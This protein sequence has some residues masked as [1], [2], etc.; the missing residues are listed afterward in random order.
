MRKIIV[1]TIGCIV[2]L[3]IFAQSEWGKAS[4]SQLEARICPID[5]SAKGMVI[6]DKQSINFKIDNRELHTYYKNYKR[7]QILKKVGFDLGNVIISANAKDAIFNVEAQI[8]NLN[9]KGE[10]AVSKLDAKQIFD[11]K[12]S[13]NVIAKKIIFPNVKEGSIIEYSYTIRADRF[14]FLNDWYF[15]SD[16]PTLSSTVVLRTP[17]FFQYTALIKSKFPLSDQKA[18]VFTEKWPSYFVGMASSGQSEVDVQGTAKTFTIKNLPA[19]EKEEYVDCLEDHLA[20]IEFVL[21]KRI[22]PDGEVTDLAKSW[23]DILEELN[24]EAEFGLLLGGGGAHI[25][26]AKLIAENSKSDLDKVKNIYEHVISKVKWDKRIRMIPRGNLSKIYS[27]GFGSSSDIN[28]ILVDMFKEVGLESD[29][30]LIRSR[31]RGRVQKQFPDFSQFSNLIAYVKLDS[32]NY[33]IDGTSTFLPFNLPKYSLFT[34]SGL[35]MNHKK[36]E[37]FDVGTNINSV[38]KIFLN[39]NMNAEM[40][41]TGKGMIQSTD[42]ESANFRSFASEKGVDGALK[43]VFYINKDVILTDTKADPLT[44][45][46]KPLRT[47]FNISSDKSYAGEDV[48]YINPFILLHREEN[49]FKLKER[50]YPI[51]FP[52]PFTETIN[53]SFIIPDGYKVTDLPKSSKTEIEGGLVSFNFFVEN[54]DKVVQINSTLVIKEKDISSNLY[55]AVKSIF[56]KAQQ[57]Y[58]SLIVL[59][60]L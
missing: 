31:Y 25:K 17:Y 49:S 20:R 34:S 44:D 3:P 32:T 7:I 9:D 53:V 18:E 26:E 30:V 46:Y 55:D 36:L 41:L 11:E 5:S 47:T 33:F 19:L 59:E 45:I 12:V 16:I 24:K 50:T 15:Q 13:D 56:E 10:V 52:Y 37:W 21:S 2:M 4:K 14:R 35:R 29:P 38:A 8:I 58:Q 28:M 39:L 42:Y 57:S 40:K 60:K 48:V 43:E 51:N 1:L 54:V 6:Y 27:D 23:T 22:S